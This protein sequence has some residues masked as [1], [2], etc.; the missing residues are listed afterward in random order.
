MLKQDDYKHHISEQF[1]CELE[2]IKNNLLKMGGKVE[3]QLSAALDALIHRDS[4]E[5]EVVIANDREVNQLEISI[6][7]DCSSI[8]ARRQPTAGDLR[9][10]LAVTKIN[11]DLERVGDEAAIRAVSVVQPAQADVRML[12]DDHVVVKQSR[13][14]LPRILAATDDDRLVHAH[15]LGS[16]G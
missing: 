11:T 5:A 7:D 6:D 13:A 12:G 8:L 3:Q 2:G 15:W 4:G 9:L 10:V 14:V 1:N 16:F